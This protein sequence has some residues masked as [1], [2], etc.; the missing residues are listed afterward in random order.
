M[1]LRDDLLPIV[2]A[3]R[4]ITGDL[5]LDQRPSKLTIRTRVWS[6]GRIGVGSSSDSELELPQHYKIREVSSREV[7]G[8][9][10]RLEIGDL[11]VVVTPQSTDGN[12]FT[13]G[14]TAEQLAP[15]FS[16]P[17]SEAIYIV[18]G[19]INGEYS[20]IDLRRDRPYR[21]VLTLRR[22]NRTP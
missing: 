5:Q 2:D 7:A 12:G 11:Q 3:V 4:A 17:G 8:S 1:T 19:Q 10:G 20:R 9:A 22:T 16:A 14:Y 15:V 21:F 6:G 18:S 13:T